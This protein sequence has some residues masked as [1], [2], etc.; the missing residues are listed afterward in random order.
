M[1]SK[2]LV[3]TRTQQTTIEFEDGVETPVLD[4]ETVGNA[5]IEG[6]HMDAQ[7]SIEADQTAA[8]ET[9]QNEPEIQ[10][11]EDANAFIGDAVYGA[12]REALEDVGFGETLPGA[13]WE[14]TEQEPLLR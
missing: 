9:E 7:L 10:S 3:V 8:D 13:W 4:L 6:A 1:S 5:M 12:P 2:K 14:S 11:L